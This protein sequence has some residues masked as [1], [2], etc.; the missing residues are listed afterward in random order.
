MCG[1]K[2]GLC[3]RERECGC[4]ETRAQHYVFLRTTHL[5]Q[6]H[7]LP[8]NPWLFRILPVDSTHTPARVQTNMYIHKHLPTQTHPH[9][10][11]CILILT[12]FRMW[13]D[14]GSV[15]ISRGDTLPSTSAP[16]RCRGASMTHTCLRR[17]SLG[18]Q[19]NAP[20]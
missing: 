3:W 4:V 5:F 10:H 18:F 8:A 2:D 1:Y 14:R 11:T 7:C 17:D 16:L 12:V 20:R 13:T 9:T 15:R 19:W 6:S